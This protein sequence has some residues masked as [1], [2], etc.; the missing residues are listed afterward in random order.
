MSDSEL[1]F[2]LLSYS[3]LVN[4]VLIWLQIPKHPLFQS[5]IYTLLQTYFFLKDAQTMSVYFNWVVHVNIKV[6][7]VDHNFF[8]YIFRRTLNSIICK[9]LT[10][11]TE[12][13]WGPW[14][15]HIRSSVSYCL[16][17][18]YVKYWHFVLQSKI[19]QNKYNFC[20]FNL[21]MIIDY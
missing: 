3:F 4:L 1:R 10:W 6:C 18:V 12:Q 2:T 9:L 21:M 11:C 7:L 16:L 15:W 8:S 20:L 14:E 19:I 5:Q 13:P 17:H